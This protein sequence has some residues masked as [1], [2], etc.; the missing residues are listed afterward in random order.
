MK[1]C[2][3]LKKLLAIWQEWGP[4]QA[5]WRSSTSRNSPKDQDSPKHFPRS[6]GQHPIKLVGVPLKAVETAYP[7]HGRDGGARPCKDRGC[8]RGSVSAC[9]LQPCRLVVA[10]PTEAPARALRRFRR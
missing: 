8:D 6:R 1:S 5:H 3:L 7:I 9:S 10:R 2:L 4:D